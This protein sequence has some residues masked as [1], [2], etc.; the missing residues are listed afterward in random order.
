MSE[1]VPSHV[2]VNP[3]RSDRADDFENWL[4]TVVVPAADQHRPESRGRWQVLRGEEADGVTPFV[5]LFYGGG[6]LADW[7]LPALLEQALGPEDGRRALR[8]AEEMFVDEQSAWSLTPVSL[9]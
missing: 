8:T 5:F 1:P 2:A 3:V 7:D 6:S 4:R 9:R